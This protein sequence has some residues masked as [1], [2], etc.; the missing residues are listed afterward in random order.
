MH[1]QSLVLSTTSCSCDPINRFFLEA[2]KYYAKLTFFQDHTI[3]SYFNGPIDNFLQLQRQFST[4]I[5]CVIFKRRKI[6]FRSFLS[7]TSDIPKRVKTSSKR[8]F[9]DLTFFQMKTT[10]ASSPIENLISKLSI[11]KKQ[12]RK[13][14]FPS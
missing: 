6:G 12:S 5:S 1:F 2:E 4:K 9:L 8:T 7:T 11:L 3:N 10:A 13:I 14:S